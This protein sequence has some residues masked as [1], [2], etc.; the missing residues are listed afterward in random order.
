MCGPDGNQ[1]TKTYP[2]KNAVK[3]NLHEWADA[4]MGRGTY[5]F[6]NDELIG[7]VAVLEAISQ[8]VENGG[9]VKL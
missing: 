1:S 8:S 4:V 3:A 9:W 7:N 6:S 5:R 2:P